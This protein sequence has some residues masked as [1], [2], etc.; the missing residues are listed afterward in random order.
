ML[1]RKLR[2]VKVEA[3]RMSL[4]HQR[5]SADVSNII[6]FV[7]AKHW[8]SV[9]GGAQSGEQYGNFRTHDALH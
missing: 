4:S 7:P 9:V 5:Q 1:R 8:L 6:E 3:V 2:P